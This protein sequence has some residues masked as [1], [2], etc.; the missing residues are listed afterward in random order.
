MEKAIAE[1]R[2]ISWNTTGVMHLL[3]GELGSFDSVTERLAFEVLRMAS[4]ILSLS[5]KPPK[6]TWFD[7]QGRKRTYTGDAEARTKDERWVLIE[8]K[9][10]GKL[11]LQS[12][13]RRKYEEIGIYLRSSGDRQFALIECE[14]RTVLARN[15]AK[16]TRYWTVDPGTVARDAFA[17]LGATTTSLAQILGVVGPERR[18]HIYA[19]LA[20][21]QLLMD[22]RRTQLSSESLVWLPSD[23]RPPFC[24]A[25]LVSTWWA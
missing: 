23:E 25:D 17:A 12:K 15:V 3:N 4:D 22:L 18:K 6:L 11:S 5:S 9:V 2:A 20:H 21:Q 8:V 14:P 13:L 24:L 19:A 1:A 7:S 16:L 10:A